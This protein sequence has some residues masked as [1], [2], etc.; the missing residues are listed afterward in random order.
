MKKLNFLKCI[1]QQRRVGGSE[2]KRQKSYASCPATH[3]LQLLA[4]MVSQCGGTG[5]I[6]ASTFILAFYQPCCSN[7]WSYPFLNLLCPFK[8][9]LE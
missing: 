3:S 4:V 2:M 5:D 8:I 9:Q 7:L 1:F 6:A